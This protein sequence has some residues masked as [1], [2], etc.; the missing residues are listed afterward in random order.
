MQPGQFEVASAE[1]IQQRVI[2][3]ARRGKTGLGQTTVSLVKL[4][5]RLATRYKLVPVSGTSLYP[6]YRRLLCG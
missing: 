5:R 6:H 3:K 2:K 4:V 1:Q